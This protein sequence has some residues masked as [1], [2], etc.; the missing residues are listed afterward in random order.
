VTPVIDTEYL[1]TRP[2]AQENL[3]NLENGPAMDLGAPVHL[4]NQFMEL[5]NCF[6]DLESLSPTA[7]SYF[8]V[9]IDWI[10]HDAVDNSFPLPEDSSSR[11]QSSMTAPPSVCL[12]G[13]DAATDAVNDPSMRIYSIYNQQDHLRA[14]PIPETKDSCSADDP[15]PMEW[16]AVPAQS[17]ALPHL[18]NTEPTEEYSIAPTCFPSIPVSSSLRMRLQS[19]L[20]LPLNHIPWHAVSISAFPS[21]EKLDRCID[22]YFTHYDNVSVDCDISFKRGTDYF[23]LGSAR[24]SSPNF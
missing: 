24:H 16:H 10:F 11:T 14:L 7:G 2:D 20:Q 12:Q 19:S 23:V 9:N 6:V 3:D 1:Y 5:S 21:K 4:E 22:L 13:E 18:G 8:D 15:W 17:F